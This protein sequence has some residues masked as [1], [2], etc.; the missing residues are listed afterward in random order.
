M[1][2]VDEY[3][4]MDEPFGGYGGINNSFIRQ[5]SLISNDSQARRAHWANRFNTSSDNQP[6][7]HVAGA[8]NQQFNAVQPQ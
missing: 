8:Y 6:D 3:A 4:E 1:N 5:N 2:Q 7:Y